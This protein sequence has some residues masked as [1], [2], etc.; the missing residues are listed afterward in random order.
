MSG[1]VQFSKLLEPYHIGRVRTRNRMIK[2]AAQMCYYN[3]DKDNDSISVKSRDFYEALAR[4]GVGLIV[5]ESPAIDYPRGM[6]APRRFRIDDDK[7]IQGYTELVNS[8]H[9]YNCPAFLELYHAG[10]W[11]KSRFS[12]LQ[13]V[14]S[15]SFYRNDIPDWEAPRELTIPEIKALTEEFGIASERAAKAGFDGIEINTA[16]SHLLSTFLS[17]FWNRRQDEYGYASIENR[18]RFVVEIIKEIKKKIGQDF[19]VSLL[20]NGAEYEA[21]NCLTVQESQSLAKLFE[22]AG[23]DAIQVRVHHFNTRGTFSTEQLF[24][25]E[26]PSPWPQELDGSHRGAGALVPLAAAIKAVVS[27][28]VITVGRLDPVIGEA[29]LRKGKADYI[30]LTRRLLADPE[31]PNKVISG[32]LDDITPCIAC[33]RCVNQN[34][35]TEPVQCTVNASLGREKEYAIEPAKLRKRIVIAGAGP[36]GMEAARV[37]AMRGHDV[38]LY[39]KERRL[40]GLLNLAALIKGTDDTLT[41]VD[42]YKNQLYKLGVKVKLNKELNTRI[43]DSENPDVLIIAGGGTPT[44]KEIPGIS[45]KKAINTTYFHGILKKFLNYIGIGMIRQLIKIWMPVGKNVVIVGGTI[46]GCELAE[47]LT[48]HNRKVSI[49]DS[50]ITMGEGLVIDTRIRLFKWFSQR[51]V[52]MITEVEPVEVTD[53][54]LV[55]CNKEVENL[56]IEADTVITALPLKPNTRLVN[57][58]KDKVKEC[59]T[60]GDCQEPSLILE[61][62]ADGSRIARAI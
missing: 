21:E 39:E 56:T 58:F 53:K 44:Q 25:P 31:L 26:P 62:I 8:I 11:H 23:A 15:S 13:A 6:T 24:Y 9:R 36:A 7:Y 34:V 19:P 5:V 55:I 18:A 52:D 59:Y 54:G 2:S 20:V 50:T 30:A 3:D 12:G 16:A 45:R 60:I 41:L 38:I 14:A 43:I 57:I 17:R 42:Y 40:G 48:K 61:A 32:K 28:P 1:R 10:P 47:F 35:F 33:L 49:V 37:L 46:H 27:I 51:G 4:G 22:T 29:I